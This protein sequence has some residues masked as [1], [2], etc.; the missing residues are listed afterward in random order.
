MAALLFCGK[1][2]IECESAMTVRLVQ[3]ACGWL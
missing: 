3:E 1:T 2:T